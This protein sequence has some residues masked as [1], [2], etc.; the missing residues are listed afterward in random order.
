MMNHVMKADELMYLVLVST[1]LLSN[2]FADVL[3]DFTCVL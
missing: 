1:E 2:Y 3:E